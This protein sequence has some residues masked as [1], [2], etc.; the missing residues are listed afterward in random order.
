MVQRVFDAQS[1]FVD[2]LNTLPQ[3][4][5]VDSSFQATNIILLDPY[6]SYYFLDVYYNRTYVPS[7][8]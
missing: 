8:V 6:T 7:Q 3:T 1:L 2:I 5:L 4:Q